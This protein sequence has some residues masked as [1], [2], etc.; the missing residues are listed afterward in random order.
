VYTLE[1]L[2]RETSDASESGGHG[3]V[4]HGGQGDYWLKGKGLKK[5]SNRDDSM[6][7]LG[8]LK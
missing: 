2:R 7:L 5:F 6:Q 4:E 3:E 1:Q 8:A